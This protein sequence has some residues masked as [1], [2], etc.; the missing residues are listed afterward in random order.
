MLAPV[1]LLGA[2]GVVVERGQRLFEGLERRDA[3]V[4]HAV[5]V[6]VRQ[7][8][9]SEQVAAAELSWIDADAARG[10]VEQHLAGEGLELPRAAVGGAPD[11]VGVEG[12]C[13]KGRL[14]HPIRAGEDHADGRRRHYR[15]R[16]RVG[17]A[18]LLEVDPHGLDGGVG[19]ERHGH[20]GVLVPGRAGGEEVLA[21]VLDPLQWC[22][23]LRR[24]QHDAH[25]VALDH[26]LLSEPAAG[27]PGDDTDAVLGDTEQPRAEQP[28][29]VGHLGGR[30]DR[31]FAGDRGRVDD[32][33]A[34]LHRHRRVALLGDGL[35]RDMG[36]RGEHLVEGGR[37]AAR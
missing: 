2:E 22:P 15:P 18:V 23:D 14:R 11:R 13:G 7:V 24:G 17:A 12:L 34:P 28:H 31:E 16:R 21:P 5:G 36:G 1:R 4:G 29:L 30:V 26:H 3:V 27:V 20:F 8:A 32:E 37:R 6:R 19:V 25:L 33:G 35:A 10:D 9:L